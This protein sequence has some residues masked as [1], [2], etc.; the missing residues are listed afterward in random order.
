M[1]VFFSYFFAPLGTWEASNC[2][3]LHYRRRPRMVTQ[4]YLHSYIIQLPLLLLFHVVEGEYFRACHFSGPQPGS[5]IQVQFT[6]ESPNLSVGIY[7]CP[8]EIGSGQQGPLEY[9]Y[10]A[11]CVVYSIFGQNGKRVRITRN[12]GLETTMVNMLMLS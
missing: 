10:F 5:C 12:S 6:F 8:Q 11:S 2:S 9:N 3:S 1:Q 7:A 4:A